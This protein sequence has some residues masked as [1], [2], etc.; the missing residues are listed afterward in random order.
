M[1]KTGWSDFDELWV[2]D[3]TLNEDTNSVI[4]E[5]KGVGQMVRYALSQNERWLILRNGGAYLLHC[6]CID[7]IIIVRTY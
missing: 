1:Q 3:S 6:W 5:Q 4:N 7:S 2:T